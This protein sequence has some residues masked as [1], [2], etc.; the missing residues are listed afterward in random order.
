MLLQD[1]IQ[2]SFLHRVYIGISMLSPSGQIYDNKLDQIICLK[3]SRMQ[4]R[5]NM[6]ENLFEG[7]QMGR[8]ADD[9]T[10][11][12]THVCLASGRTRCFGQ[13]NDFC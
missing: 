5:I 1:L 11:W 10:I 9:I 4:S 3:R 8:L 12:T 2:V 13:I 6:N 7:I